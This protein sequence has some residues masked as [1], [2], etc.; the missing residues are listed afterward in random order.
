M[1]NKKTHEKKVTENSFEAEVV[2][3]HIDEV[4]EPVKESAPEE[5]AHDKKP[6]IAKDIDPNQIVT[7]L[8]GHQGRLV[9][10][11]KRTGEKFVWDEFGAE[12][13]MELSELKNAKSASKKYFANNWFM[14]DEPW[15]IDYLGMGQ[16]YKNAIPIDKFDEFFTKPHA[17]LE[18]AIAKLSVGQKK[19]LAYRAKQLIATGDIDSNK[20]ISILEKC[21][22]TELIE[23]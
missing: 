4:D 17:E 12:Q 15:I 19:S 20:T 23:R 8:N 21:L 10:K 16:F 1:S 9:Y 5:S 2:E 3:T 7:V 22:E 18:D 6:V 11:S 14:F 13:D